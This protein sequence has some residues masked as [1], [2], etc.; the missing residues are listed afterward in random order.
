MSLYFSVII[1]PVSF[2]IYSFDI[3]ND[4]IASMHTSKYGNP[5]SPMS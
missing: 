3:M 5:K 2:G 4:V 1:L